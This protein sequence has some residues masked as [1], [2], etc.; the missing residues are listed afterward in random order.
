M[1]IKCASLFAASLLSLSF[2][3]TV[4]AAV[5]LAAP[6][7]RFSL[8]D[9]FSPELSRQGMVVSEEDIASR[10]GAEVLRNGGNAVD[11][12]VAVGIAL[13]V[14]LP[15]AG[16]LGG[17]GFMLVHLAKSNKTIAIDYRE[18]APGKA[19]RDMFLNADGS[20]DRDELARG[21]T[22]I[23]VPG[24]VAGL[25][26]ALEKYGTM[27]WADLIK[28]AIALAKEGFVLKPAHEESFARAQSRLGRNAESKRI[29]LDPEGKA[30]PF[31]TKLVQADLAWSLTELAKEGPKAFYQGEIGKRL[32]ADIQANGGIMTMDDLAQYKVVER[33]PV[34]GDYRGYQIVSMPPPSSGGV[35]L[36]QMLNVL[37]A[38][39]IKE[40][41]LNSAQ[42]IHAMIETERRAYADRSQHLGDPD[43][44]KV[45]VSQLL[46]KKYA[47]TIRAQINMQRATPSVLVQPG[48][49]E[50]YESPQTTHYSVMD[51]DGNAVANTYTLNWSYGT[52]LTAKGTGI[53]LNN[54]M[55]DFS[56]KPGTTNAYG[57]VG[58]EANAVQPR[59]RPLSSMTPTI[60][61]KDGKVFLVT[62]SP[63]GSTIITT[64]L[65]TV[66]N[67]IDHGLNVQAA[68]NQPRFHHQWRPDWVRFE[69]GFSVDTLN[70]LTAKGHL[71]QIGS[72]LGTTESIMYRDGV[73]HGAADPR[74]AGGGAV[75]PEHL[76]YSW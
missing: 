40:W 34:R 47:E 43:F 67:V 75:G 22:G 12:A 60:V 29:F 21:W 36:I 44:F 42:T 37:E 41:G 19:H 6:E 56:A 55:D 11:A 33:E 27:K 17:G 26:H 73:F 68:T 35:H 51:K 74:R 66:M 64:V 76:Q 2:A 65:Q 50:G 7:A 61:M 20:V 62:G 4:Q 69:A 10:I 9:V 16:N 57:L 31:G 28:P 38:Y 1:S 18:M 54:E 70:A 32:I 46:S 45:P 39:D 63:G 59:K 8:S 15:E 71:I 13:A 25:H 24:T 58:A 48:D 5:P 52:G 49:L 23:G 30:L 3:S 53:L 72:P 14:V